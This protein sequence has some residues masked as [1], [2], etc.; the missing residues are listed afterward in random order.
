MMVEKHS[1]VA[2]QLQEN[3][4]LL[5][6]GNEPRATIVNR[7]AMSYLQETTDTFDLI[8]LD[9]PYRKGLLAK[10][11]DLILTLT[12]LKSGGLIYLEHE[13]EEQ[14]EWSGWNLKPIKRSEAGVA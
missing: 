9:P 10:S 7:D 14:F 11:L 4:K 6:A 13:A 8:F 3:I 5:E 1:R 12:V 2:Q